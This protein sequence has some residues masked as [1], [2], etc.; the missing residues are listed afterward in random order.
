[1]IDI[2]DLIKRQS[3]I[4]L[5]QI[6]KDEIDKK[7][8]CYFDAS[9]RGKSKKST[10][11]FVVKNYYDDIIIEHIDKRYC[12]DPNIAELMALDELINWLLYN[13]ISSKDIIIYGDS[14]TVIDAV[15][16]NSRKYEYI[17]LINNLNKLKLQNNIKIEWISG[18]NNKEADILSKI[19]N[20]ISDEFDRK[21]AYEE[22]SLRMLIKVDKSGV[23]KRKTRK[24]IEKELKIEYLLWQ[25]GMLT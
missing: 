13:K 3:I 6:S 12:K 8:Y 19:E 1:M 17:E 25:L 5:M 2:L 24:Q 16:C 18:L 21:V 7:Y 22:S 9:F 14:K 10:L 15:N 20:N 11:A 23:I 4:R